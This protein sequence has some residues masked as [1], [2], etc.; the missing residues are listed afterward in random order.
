MRR[1]DG[2]VSGFGKHARIVC[3]SCGEVNYSLNFHLK[4]VEE[5]HREQRKLTNYEEVETYG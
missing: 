4:H 5:Y 2:M 3:M 1:I